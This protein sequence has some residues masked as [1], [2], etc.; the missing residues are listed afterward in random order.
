MK[1]VQYALI[2]CGI[3]SAYSATDSHLAR[4][5][6]R[7]SRRIISVATLVDPIWV[8]RMVK[9]KL[10]ISHSSPGNPRKADHAALYIT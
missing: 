9:F 1:K 10:R 2:V 7:T 4:L 3:Y 8:E 5:D 6:E